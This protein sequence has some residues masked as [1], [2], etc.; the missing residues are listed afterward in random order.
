MMIRKLAWILGSGVG[1]DTVRELDGLFRASSLDADNGSQDTR[2]NDTP[3]A[4]G[5]ITGS[6]GNA[7]NSTMLNNSTMRS[8]RC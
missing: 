5:N 1:D 4:S 7:S 8:W 2:K 3:E 6:P